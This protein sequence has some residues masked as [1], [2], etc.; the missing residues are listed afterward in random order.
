MPSRLI[1]EDDVPFDPSFS[2]KFP[3]LVR[4]RPADWD[5]VFLGAQHREDPASIAENVARVCQGLFARFKCVDE[6]DI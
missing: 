1:L 2:E 3:V 5:M 4:G 6:F